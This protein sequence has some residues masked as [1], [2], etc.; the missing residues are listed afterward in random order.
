MVFGTLLGRRFMQGVF[1]GRGLVQ[2]LDR[3]KLW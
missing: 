2:D 1:A 3:L